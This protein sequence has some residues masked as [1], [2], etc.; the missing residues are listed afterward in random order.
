MV[1][2]LLPHLGAALLPPITSPPPLTALRQQEGPRMLEMSQKIK[3]LEAALKHANPDVSHWRQKHCIN[4]LVHGP[5]ASSLKCL[6]RASCTR[7]YKA[8]PKA[9]HT[10]QVD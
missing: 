6:A 5:A 4:C 2:V 3:S 1:D 8:A 10:L 9:I 7:P